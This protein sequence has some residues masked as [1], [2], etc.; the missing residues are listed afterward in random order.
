MSTGSFTCCLQ[1]TVDIVD[2]QFPVLF[3]KDGSFCQQAVLCAVFAKDRS[4]CQQAVDQE[5]I[6]VSRKLCVLAAEEGGDD[7]STGSF[8]CCQ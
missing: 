5:I 6:F 2:R 1:K 3:A 7:L 4:F 8:V